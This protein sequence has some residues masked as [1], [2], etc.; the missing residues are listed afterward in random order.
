VEARR[1]FYPPLHTLPQCSHRAELPR[2][3]R[4]CAA[5]ICLPLHSTMDEPVLTQIE[6]A[7]DA[8]AEEL[9]LRRLQLGVATDTTT[10]AHPSAAR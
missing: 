2:T 3:E 1:Y 6:T 5:Q 4:L 7:I 10:T 8:V 9:G